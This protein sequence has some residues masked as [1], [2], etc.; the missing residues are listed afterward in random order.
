MVVGREGRDLKQ[1][2]CGAEASPALRA[3]RKGLAST[4]P[5][6]CSPAP[7]RTCQPQSR[8]GGYTQ[9]S[10]HGCE[11]LDGCKK[12]LEHFPSYSH[13]GSRHC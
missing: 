5:P 1:A 2:V 4:Q 3:R 12:R 7:H 11:R 13:K 10:F 8:E 9:N 6:E